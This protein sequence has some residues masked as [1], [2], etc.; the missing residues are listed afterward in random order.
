VAL[1][2]VLVVAGCG[3]SS[4]KDDEAKI[5][6]TVTSFFHALAASDAN[7]ACSLLTARGKETLFQAKTQADC[8]T[9]VRKVTSRQGAAATRTR[10]ELRGARIL[11]VVFKSDERANVDVQLP[12]SNA[13]TAPFR[14]EKRG[15][16]WVIAGP[17]NPS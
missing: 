17:V 5:K 3:G 10:R 11:T 2:A 8:E 15:D 1:L 9:T 12:S 13:P 6:T 14:V 7:K 16:R 4:R